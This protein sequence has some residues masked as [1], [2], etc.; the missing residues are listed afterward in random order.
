MQHWQ[1]PQAAQDAAAAA[2]ETPWAAC[3]RL[4]LSVQQWQQR[5]SPAAHGF[6]SIQASAVA[7]T[8]ELLNFL[9]P[10]KRPCPPAS[11]PGARLQPQG[12]GD[13][14]RG[15]A[16]HPASPAASSHGG[17]SQGSS[18]PAQTLLHVASAA[19]VVEALPAVAAGLGGLCREGG[20][21][22]A[23][24]DAARGTLGYDQQSRGVL[25][26]AF[27]MSVIFLKSMGE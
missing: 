15:A 4:L 11:Q 23:A 7:S 13:V 21:L 26:S 18:R 17:S 8:I 27:K 6:I 3:G 14:D 10:A 19:T 20:R 22:A 2:V 25:H 12:V 5:T 16:A 1:Q 9:L 24:P